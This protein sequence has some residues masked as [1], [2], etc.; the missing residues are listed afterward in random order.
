MRY[1]IN[2]VRYIRMEESKN[3][4][5]HLKATVL[6]VVSTGILLLSVFYSFLN[7]TSMRSELQKEQ[8]RLD[9]IELQYQRYQQT[10]T[11]IDKADLEL[12]DRLQGNRIFWT[13]KL[14]AIAFHLPNKA[15]NPY[16][17]TNFSYNRNIF[18]VQGYGYISPRQEQLITIDDYLNKLR[19][20]TTYNQVFKTTLL[21]STQRN[22]EGNRQRVN[23]EFSSISKGAIVR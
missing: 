15:P 4:A 23:F 8:D 18:N 1:E 22:D 7:V 5:A 11:I 14:A 10:Q 19:A 12:L 17:I 2:M 3:E 13:E 6:C 9:V 21:R 16:W 20:D